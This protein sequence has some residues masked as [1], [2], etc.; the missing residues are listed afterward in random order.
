M[1]LYSFSLV[2]EEYTVTISPMSVDH[3]LRMKVF[4]SLTFYSQVTDSKET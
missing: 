2:I 3:I 1:T 4:I